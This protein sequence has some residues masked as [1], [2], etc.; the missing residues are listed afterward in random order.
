MFPSSGVAAQFTLSLK[1]VDVANSNVPV[2]VGTNLSSTNGLSSERTLKRSLIVEDNFIIATENKRWLREI[3]FDAIV[4]VSNIPQAL[5]ELN[6]QSFDFC[7]LDVNLR[8]AL[9]K[10][11][12]ARLTE[13]GIPY[14][15]ASGYGSEGS[16]MCDSFN[17]PY[18]T[19]PISFEQ[20]RTAVHDL[21]FTLP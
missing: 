4:A 19:K 2:A 20:L 10:P 16:Q 8:G 11:V 13:L 17:A 15:F 7:L 1:E 21:G 9:S 6:A 12:A 5:S 14:V 3:G 18:L